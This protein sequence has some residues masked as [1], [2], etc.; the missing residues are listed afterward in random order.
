MIIYKKLQ[1]CRI[2]YTI[3]HICMAPNTFTFRHEPSVQAGWGHLEDENVQIS[4]RADGV[5]SPVDEVSDAIAKNVEQL[6]V[7]VD[8]KSKRVKTRFLRFFSNDESKPEEQIEKDVCVTEPTEHELPL[9]RLA[10]IEGKGR[11]RYVC[12]DEWYYPYRPRRWPRGSACIRRRLCF[13]RRPCNHCSLRKRTCVCNS[14]RN[15]V[16]SGHPKW[17]PPAGRWRSE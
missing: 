1:Y 12:F 8:H 14:R 10:I 6:G 3:R 5:F 2:S 17:S 9:G 7:Q 15:E 4:R 11:G 13:S 16:K